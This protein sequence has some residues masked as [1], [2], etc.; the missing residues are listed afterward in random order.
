M[1]NDAHFMLLSLRLLQS[2]S[3]L[4]MLISLNIQHV[5]SFVFI[6]SNKT[7]EI[8]RQK[9]DEKE[10]VHIFNERQ[11]NRRRKIIISMFLFYRTFQGDLVQLK[12]FPSGASN[13]LKSKA[14]DQLV[15]AHG[16]RH[17]NINPLIGKE[18]IFLCLTYHQLTFILF[19]NVQFFL[20]F[21]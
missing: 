3:L 4:W 2:L 12:E 14:M 13:E 9:L 16:L 10:R 11:R 15:M 19:S 18:M 6:C 20:L 8:T 5:F 21:I 1:H 7:W 17:E